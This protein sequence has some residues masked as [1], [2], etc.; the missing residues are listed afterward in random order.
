MHLPAQG[1]TDAMYIHNLATPGAAQS[2][3]ANFQAM[4]T[5]ACAL[6]EL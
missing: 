3:G 5:Q 2:W 4:V 1:E 6:F